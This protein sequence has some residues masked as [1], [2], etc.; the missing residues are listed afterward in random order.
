MSEE[1]AV[2]A[3]GYGSN[4]SRACLAWKGVPVLE[5]S[6]GALLAGFRRFF[7]AESGMANVRPS[8]GDRVYGV[9]HRM[10]RRVKD[11]LD[12]KEG[13]GTH[14]AHQTVPV[15]FLDSDQSVLAEIYCLREG[16]PC[17]E[18]LPTLRYRNILLEGAREFNLPEAE[19]RA[20]E[21]Q[22]CEPDAPIEQ[23]QWLEDPAGP[24]I[25]DAELAELAKERLVFVFFG[26]VVEAF[27]DNGPSLYAILDKQFR[28]RNLTKAVQ[29]NYYYPN[30][31][32]TQHD[33]FL[34]HEMQ[35][36]LSLK[37]LGKYVGKAAL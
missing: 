17:A 9:L 25:D 36:R 10:A 5:G 29:S 6:R 32:P 8:P 30:L 24:L 22:P 26:R 7:A 33:L 28:G 16:A 4:M 31:D 20:L 35:R 3:F 37:V 2:W 21:Q 27:P 34:H 18:G 13:G 19:I 14:Y 12:R 1:E 15:F 23:W 11:E